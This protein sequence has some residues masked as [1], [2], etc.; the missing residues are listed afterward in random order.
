VTLSLWSTSTFCSVSTGIQREKERERQ[1]DRETQRETEREKERETETEREREKQRER[2]TEIS[3]L[4]SQE[5]GTDQ[6]SLSIYQEG[7]TTKTGVFLVRNEFTFTCSAPAWLSSSLFSFQPQPSALL[8]FHVGSTSHLSH[9]FRYN[10]LRE[11]PN[12]RPM[13][14]PVFLLAPT[15]AILATH[16]EL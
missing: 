14:S 1:R 12:S 11:L 6:A 3:R 5:Q 8:C 15:E 16:S 7:L 13:T 4:Y 2:E 9:Q 10:F